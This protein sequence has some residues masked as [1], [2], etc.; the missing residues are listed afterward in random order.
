M[1]TT[2]KKHANFV[3]ESIKD[4][5]ISDVPGIGMASGI[6]LTK[7]GYDTPYELLGQ[8]LLLKKNKFLFS[9]WLDMENVGLNKSNIEKCA[10]ALSEY[11]DNFI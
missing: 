6:G 9:A 1:T 8:F 11:S 10:N 4:K 7:K 5:I 2:T 3:T